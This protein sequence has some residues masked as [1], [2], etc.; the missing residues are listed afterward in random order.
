MS[1]G[2]AGL[3]GRLVLAD[4]RRRTA[5]LDKTFDVARYRYRRPVSL[6]RHPSSSS[7]SWEAEFQPLRIRPAVV[8]TSLLIADVLTTRPVAGGAAGGDRALLAE[9]E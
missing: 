9:S 7:G 5:T 2:P 6:G 3:G 1:A 4:S 8:V